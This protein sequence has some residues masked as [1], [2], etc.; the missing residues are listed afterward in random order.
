MNKTIAYLLA[1]CGI[2]SQQVTAQEP[3]A[4]QANEISVATA[5]MMAS[6]GAGNYVDT[7]LLARKVLALRERTDGSDHLETV[8]ARNILA[9]ACLKLR[10]FDEAAL[11]YSR[12]LAIWE[13]AHGPDDLETSAFLNSF[14]HA[15]SKWAVYGRNI[16]A[17]SQRFETARDALLRALNIRV[18]KVGP[19]D[20]L[21]GETLCNLAMVTAFQ[22]RFDEAEN[23]QLRALQIQEHVLGPDHPSTKESRLSL[24]NIRH[25]RQSLSVVSGTDLRA[26]QS[27]TVEQAQSLSGFFG[28][29]DLVSVTEITYGVA[30]A[31]AHHKGFVLDLSGVTE[32]TI[33][34]AKALAHHEE[35]LI[36][37]GLVG[38]SD[39][40]AAALADHRGN[41]LSLNGL[42]SVSVDAATSLARYQGSLILGGVTHLSS[43]A[44]AALARHKGLVLLSGLTDVPAD[45]ALALR[46]NPEIK[47]PESL[48]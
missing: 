28:L 19:N 4:P 39:G 2:G 10:K 1:C 29:L 37:D 5:Q 6:Y 26:V 45:G 34:A 8:P 44:A 22:R 42:T 35:G 32:L 12:N 36:L 38:L 7:E 33:E 13:R 15:C 25:D 40:T 46:A 14:G 18:N 9:W 41:T 48:R 27:L 3:V 20:M 43:T 23:L 17:K 11:L 31:L 16:D 24:D 47:L 30:E 21:V